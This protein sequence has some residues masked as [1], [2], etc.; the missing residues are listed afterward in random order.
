MKTFES[1]LREYTGLNYEDVYNLMPF[2]EGEMVLQKMFDKWVKQ[3]RPEKPWIMVTQH[4]LS[5]L[6][7]NIVLK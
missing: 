2:E 4:I 6:G 7:Y 1:F 5:N 3:R